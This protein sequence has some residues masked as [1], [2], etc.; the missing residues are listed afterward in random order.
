MAAG[1][2][3]VTG[4]HRAAAVADD[5]GGG[6]G[7]AG[8]GRAVGAGRSHLV[9]HGTRRGAG[10]L[11]GLCVA[12]PGVPCSAAARA[13]AGAAGGGA[14]G[15]GDRRDRCVRDAG[16]AV[17]AVA[18]IAARRT[19]AGAGA[20]VYRVDDFADHRPGAARRVRYPATGPERAGGDTRVAGHVAGAA[21][22]AADQCAG[23]PRLLPRVPLLLGLE[24]VLRPFF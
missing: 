6:G 14:F 18:G 21:D 23:V 13:L 9:A 3:A 11:C 16:G 2:R 22:P 17:P 19:G 1:V 7:D 5:A 8:L 15:R 12:G 24:L 10:G 20:G 4:P